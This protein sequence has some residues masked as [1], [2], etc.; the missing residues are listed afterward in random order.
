MLPN[1]WISSFG[2]MQ[3][4]VVHNVMPV[5][6]WSGGVF[7]QVGSLF[8]AEEGASSEDEGRFVECYG[9]GREYKDEVDKV[10]MK[11]VFAEGL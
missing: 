4:F 7:D 3:Q 5:S 2:G 11:F 9:V 8:K 6:T 1:L 10:V